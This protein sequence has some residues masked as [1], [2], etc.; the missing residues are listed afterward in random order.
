MPDREFSLP[1]IFFR[2]NDLFYHF[3]AQKNLPGNS[4][5]AVRL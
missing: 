2:A 5:Q 1:G 3:Q 4:G